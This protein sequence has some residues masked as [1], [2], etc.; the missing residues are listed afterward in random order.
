MIMRT[1]VIPVL[2]LDDGGLVKT[3]KFKNP[4]YVGDPINT[5]RIFNEKE[6]D[7]IAFI[8]IS[9]TNKQEDPDFDLLYSI[10]GE[11]FM[12]MSYGGGIKTADQAKKIFSIGFEK[13]ILNSLTYDAPDVVKEISQTYGAQAVVACLD[14]KRNFLG[15]YELFTHS[16]KN[17]KKVSLLEH[18]SQLQDMG[19]GEIIVNSIDRDGTQSGYDINLLTQLNNKVSVPLVACG[20]AASISDFSEAVKAGAS[21]VAAGAMFVFRGKHRAVL[22]SYP[23]RAALKQALP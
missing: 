11:A 10:A 23:E 20:G 1:R 13:V 18:V 2:L 14:V 4:V 8:D 7:E 5:I 17:K 9:A 19:V 3:T 21:A 12:P 15:K 6:V 16:A 22:V